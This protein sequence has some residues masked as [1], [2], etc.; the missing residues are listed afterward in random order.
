M[1]H[2]RF[3]SVCSASRWRQLVK[4]AAFRRSIRARKRRSRTKRIARLL[5]QPDILAVKRHA[6]GDGC[7]SRRLG[8]NLASRI[9]SKRPALRIPAASG[10]VVAKVVGIISSMRMGMPEA[11][12]IWLWSIHRA[13]PNDLRV[14]IKMMK[15]SPTPGPLSDDSPG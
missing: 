1:L 12:I 6:K 8:R 11:A 5:G 13:H 7:D 15:R 10:I 2:C 3:P 4:R 14:H 9:Y